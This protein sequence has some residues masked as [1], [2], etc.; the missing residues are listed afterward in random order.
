M[1]FRINPR[2]F[3][4]LRFVAAAMNFTVVSAAKWHG[5]FVTHLA[6][7]RAGLR[8]SQVMGVRGLT[9]TD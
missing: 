9:C 8:E 1:Q 7:K 4:P 3:P 5:E 6:C 2:I